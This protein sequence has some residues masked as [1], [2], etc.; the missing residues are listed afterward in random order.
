MVEKVGGDQVKM[1]SDA[2]LMTLAFILHMLGAREGFLSRGDRIQ[3][4][5]L[6]TLLAAG[7]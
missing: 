1:T 5:S 6:I 7:V 2:L 3:F 4:R